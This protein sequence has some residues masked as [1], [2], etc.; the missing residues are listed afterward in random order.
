MAYCHIGLGPNLTAWLKS[1]V[2]ET[3]PFFRDYFMVGN[4]NMTCASLQP[5][6]KFP[7]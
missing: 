6:E 1:S 7:R 2:Q 3:F 5:G 4:V